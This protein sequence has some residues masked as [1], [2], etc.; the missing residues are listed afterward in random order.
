MSYVAGGCPAKVPA[1]FRFPGC[2]SRRKF[3][4]RIRA[5]A[6]ETR[7][8]EDQF[9]RRFLAARQPGIRRGGRGRVAAP[10][11]KSTTR[12]SLRTHSRRSISSGSDSETKR[13]EPSASAKL[14][15]PPWLLP[16]AQMRRS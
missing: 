13:T 3:R 16:K 15:P 2:L 11:Q 1:E 12:P 5:L 10:A 6:E 7:E 9:G 8:T 14:A 4:G